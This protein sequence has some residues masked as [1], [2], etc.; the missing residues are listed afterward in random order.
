MLIS[1]VSVG[2]WLDRD[3]ANFK[4]KMAAMAKADREKGIDNGAEDAAGR[5][6]DG[7]LDPKFPIERA[8][9]RTLPIS[10]GIYIACLAGYGWCLQAKVN[11]AGP[12]MLQIVSE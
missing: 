9:L 4:A 10:L 11:I 1:S 7:N 8:R 3:Y 12:L 5:D 6:K 2:K